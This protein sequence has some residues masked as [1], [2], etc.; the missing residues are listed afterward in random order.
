[1]YQRCT[2]EEKFVLAGRQN[3][4]ARRA[5]YPVRLVS[6]LNVYDTL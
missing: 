3:Q 4:H 6:H 1:M 5:R 2:R